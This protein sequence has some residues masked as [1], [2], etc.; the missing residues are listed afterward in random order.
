MSDTEDPIKFEPK[1][2]LIKIVICI[3]VLLVG[4]AVFMELERTKG[5]PTSGKSDATKLKE[6]LAEKY[7]ISLMDL[8]QLETAIGQEAAEKDDAE[9]PSRWTYG[10][11]VFFAFTIMTTIGEY[12]LLELINNSIIMA[13]KLNDTFKAIF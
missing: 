10:N 4:A 12:I 7:N 9:R 3:L 1:S 13:D 6:S 2:L 11:S 8:E 5:E